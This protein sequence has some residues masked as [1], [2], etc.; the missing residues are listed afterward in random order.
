MKISAIICEYN[1]LHNGHLSHIA[2]TKKN[3]DALICVMSG[4]FVQRGT[5]AIMDKYDRAKHAVLSGADLVLELPTVFATA[6]AENFSYGAIK[7]LDALKA[8]SL[9][10]G[11]ECGDLT[12]LS[13]CADFLLA[14]PKLI[15][16]KI[17]AYITLG[18]S[19]PS[20]IA[21]A[22]IEYDAEFAI[23]DKPNNLLAVEY[24]KQ[25]KLQNSKLKPITLKRQDN[26]NSSSIEGEFA[27]STS[28]RSAIESKMTE[29]LGEYMPKF[30]IDDLIPSV[31]DKYRQFVYSF[32][33]TTTAEYL[34][35]IEGV[36]E[37]LENRILDNINKGNYQLMFDGI[38]TKR[39]TMVKLQRVLLSAVLNITKDKVITA[40]KM[41]P[42][43]KVLAVSEK[44]LDLLSH[45][46]RCG[47]NTPPSLNAEQQ[48]VYEI[49]LKASNLFCS[50]AGVVGNK[51]LTMPLQKII[52]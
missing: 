43:A 37:G 1:P 3:C 2:F 27:S 41:H 44:R 33:H 34:N 51:D 16:D 29:N 50:L 45:I 28:I 18:Q 5:P 24:L 52:T 21:K 42:Y 35:N 40:K 26:F 46:A 15:T 47:I 48:S 9:S 19:Y 23:L 25:I 12:V 20:A 7:L 17:K 8:D 4:N 22:M 10:F 14:P 39:Y 11:S 13:R 31:N 49:D 30:V 36:N 32:L 38:K 6:S